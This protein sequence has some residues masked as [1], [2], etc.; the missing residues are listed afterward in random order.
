MTNNLH[1]LS[2]EQ[3]ADLRQQCSETIGAVHERLEQDP[4]IQSHVRTLLQAPDMLQALATIQHQ[5]RQQAELLLQAAVA[6]MVNSQSLKQLENEHRRRLT[7][8]N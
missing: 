1:G 2:D 5:N 7:D 6:V 3:L 8:R 4:A